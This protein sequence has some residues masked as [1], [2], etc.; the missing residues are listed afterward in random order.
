[1][2]QLKQMT[3][4]TGGCAVWVVL[5]IGAMARGGEYFQLTAQTTSGTA[6]TVS[7]AGSS[8]LD[9][10]DDVLKRQGAFQM[11]AGH[12]FVGNLTYGGVRNAV[13]LTANADVTS[14][15]LELPP[16]GFSRTFTGAN[17]HDVKEQIK[18]FFKK[19]GAAEYA[20]FL[21][22]INELS[23]VAAVDG[24]PQAAT[25]FLADQ[26]F[27]HFGLQTTMSLEPKT[28]DNNN[29]N[30]FEFDGGVIHT[31]VVNG[32]YLSFTPEG[33]LR[34]NDHLAL[35]IA[36]PFQYRNLQ[37]SDVF[38]LGVEVG[39]PITIVNARGNGLIWQITPFA[40]GGA[41]GSVDLAAGGV[42][43][44]GGA[45]NML[46][47]KAGALTFVMG[48][49]ISYYGGTR[50]RGKDWRFETDV[51]QPIL[52]NGGKVVWNINEGF[53]V[54]AG[55]TYTNF[56]HDAAIP[57][58][59]SPTA[60]VGVR[61]GRNRESGLRVGY[62]GDYGHGYKASGGDVELYFNY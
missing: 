52:K 24:N 4:W 47:L 5:A 37:D 30:G 16:T 44:G 36:I 39:M 49:Q 34:F 42:L 29:H 7:A 26:S 15:T 6:E 10:T 1:M 55:V 22:R 40:S 45:T 58:Y 8:L 32:Y 48:N 51:N 13:R 46:A 28:S 62:S 23:P 57:D 35:S 17:E 61:F 19:H 56:L 60:G 25:A 14:V 18:D 50:I 53:Y 9:L 11:L 12:A 59:W 3:R 43:M 33:V 38:T 2:K 31:D 41:V 27:R 54:D 20:T 21:K